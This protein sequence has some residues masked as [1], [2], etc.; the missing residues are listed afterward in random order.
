MV[1]RFRGDTIL[2]AVGPVT[3][4][5]YMLAPGETVLLDPRDAVV[6]VRDRR[7]QI[8]GIVLLNDATSQ[9][10]PSQRPVSREPIR[11]RDGGL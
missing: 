2:R 6:M 10:G 9:T 5:S 8:E 1:I 4:A 11:D 7:L 3:G